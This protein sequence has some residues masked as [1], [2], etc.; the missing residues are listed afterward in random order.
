MR[1]DYVN[2]G[3]IWFTATFLLELIWPAIKFF[4]IPGSEE[5]L[6][7]DEAF[8]ILMVLGIPVFTFVLSVLG[9]SFVRFRVHEDD[10]QTDGPPVRSSTTVYVVWLVVTGLLALAVLI[11][12]GITGV[13]ELRSNPTA[14]LIV[15]VQAE[16][17]NW[18]FSYPQ[19]GIVV[20]KADQLIL[21]VDTRVKF[22][23]S[24]TDILHSFWI[25]AFRMKMDAVPG[26][27]NA[28]YTTP[29]VISAFDDDSNFRVQCAE[30]CGTGHARMRAEVVVIEIE[31]FESWVAEMQPAS[32]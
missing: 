2:V 18:T 16:K 17:W 27:T 6:L 29:N 20:E 21:P 23:V 7:I 13:F 12:P 5:G 1:R 25:P 15:E 30:L 8:N 32:P 14:D 9:Y 4:G 28:L 31:E 3:V 19:Y 11:H 10:T 24:S 22:E 26:Q